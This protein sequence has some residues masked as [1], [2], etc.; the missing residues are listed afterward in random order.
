MRIGH[1]LLRGTPSKWGIFIV[2]SWKTRYRPDNCSTSWILIPFLLLLPP[3]SPPFPGLPFTL[4]FFSFQSSNLLRDLLLCGSFCSSPSHL[5]SEG[6]L[7]FPNPEYHLPGE[8]NTPS[9][10]NRIK[11]PVLTNLPITLTRQ[12]TPLQ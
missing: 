6:P 3:L 2:R 10:T 1:L 5:W 4:H 7:H 12:D 11:E 8:S 9:P